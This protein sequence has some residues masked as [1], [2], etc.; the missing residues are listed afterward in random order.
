MF[1]SLLPHRHLTNERRERSGLLEFFCEKTPKFNKFINFFR[2]SSETFVV[3]HW[4]SSKFKFSPFSHLYT[5][6]QSLRK[7]SD[8]LF[9]KFTKLFGLWSLNPSLERCFQMLSDNSTSTSFEASWD[10]HCVYID[11]GGSR[12]KVTCVNWYEQ[13]QAS[14]GC[15]QFWFMEVIEA[16]T[17][18]EMRMMCSLPNFKQIL[19]QFS[20]VLSQ[21]NPCMFPSIRHWT[22]TRT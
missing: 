4:K 2:L 17:L 22:L 14:L 9:L 10:L 15:C 13:S 1:T 21:E 18:T 19:S 12:R 8:C 16:C 3:L 5:L 6:S 20:K 7:V 11:G